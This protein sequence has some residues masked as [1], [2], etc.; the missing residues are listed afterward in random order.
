[1][2]RSNLKLSFLLV[3]TGLAVSPVSTFAASRGFEQPPARVVNFGD[4]D[5]GQ[6]AGVMTLYSR[7]KSAAREVCEPLDGIKVNLL[8]KRYDC[9]QN[10]VERAVAEV[11]SPALTNYY[12]GKGKNFASNQAQ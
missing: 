1:M 5:L 3:L 7:I 12:L 8:H 11:N 2:L 6:K 9:K 4:L 10:A